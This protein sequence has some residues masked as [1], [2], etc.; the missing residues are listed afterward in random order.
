MFE[1]ILEKLVALGYIG[2]F[3]TSFAGTTSIV[4][5]IPYVPILLAAAL[6]GKFNPALLALAAGLGSGIG[7]MVGYAI[8][9][10]GRK[11]IGEKY[12]RRFTALAKIFSKY[13]AIAIYIFAL[14]PLPDDLII[15]PLGLIKYGFWRA[16]I[17]CFLGKLSMCT[18]VAYFGA[19]ASNIVYQ[20]YGEAGVTSTI[21]AAIA[22]SII[23]ILLFKIDW[24]KV[25]EKYLGE[26]LS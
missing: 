2:I 13:G 1:D 17:P 16:F 23:L 22:L 24:E 10:A 9:R 3:I 14:T 12:E 7:E 5:P 18:I 20:L 8:G 15:I 26:K 19:Y 4:I 25:L 6:S 11:V 21:I